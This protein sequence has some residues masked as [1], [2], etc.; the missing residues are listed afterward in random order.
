MDLAKVKIVTDSSADLLSIENVPFAVAPLKM[1]AT[2]GE[3]VDD[4]KLD[5][6]KMLNELASNEDRVTTSCPSEGDWLDCFGDAEYVFCVT[7]TSGLSGSYNAACLAKKDY[8]ERYPERKVC[9]ID[10]LSAGSELI[11]IVE[12][13]QELIL[14]GKSFEE[15]EE[16][17]AQYQKKTHLLFMLESLKNLKNNG[18]VSGF[19]A[20]LAGILGIRGVGVASARGDLEPVSKAKGDKM[21]L[22]QIL[23][24]MQEKGFKGG[25]VHIGHCRNEELALLLKEKL[26]SLFKKTE[27][28]IHACRGLCSFYAEEGGLMVGFEG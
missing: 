12:K 18:R 8:E 6:E 24:V 7:M 10:S 19:T 14:A 9:V 17:I 28:I 2:T 15:V 26:T 27:V 4:E 16:E 13:L 23:K 21:T 20:R 22:S 11:L 5:V 25:K 3:Y 1:I